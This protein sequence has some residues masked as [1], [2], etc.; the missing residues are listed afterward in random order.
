[1]YK[2]RA[3]EINKLY[4]ANSFQKTIPEE[5]MEMGKLQEP[6]DTLRYLPDAQRSSDRPRRSKEQ[7]T[8]QRGMSSLGY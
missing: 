2:E 3:A 6:R 4:R 8:E 1:M 7:T 5:I